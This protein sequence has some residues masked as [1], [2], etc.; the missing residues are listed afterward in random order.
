MTISEAKRGRIFDIRRFSTHDGGGIRTTVFFK[1]CP[2]RCKWC[3]N[4][5]GIDFARRPLWFKG[6]CMGCGSCVE[7]A[8]KGGVTMGEDGVC[9]HPLADENWDA[10]MEACPTLAIRWDSRDMTAD[11]VMNELRRDMAFYAHGGGV[12]LSGGDPLFQPEFAL[13]LLERCREAG[14][15]TAVETELHAS[16][17]SVHAVLPHADLIYADLKLMDGG[18]HREYTGADN[19]LILQNLSWL[20]GGECGERVVVRTPLIPGMTATEENIAA[21]AAYLAGINAAVQYEL[22]NYNPLAAAKYPLVDRDFC[23]D[24]NPR[25]FT[26]AEMEAF[27]DIARAQGLKNVIWE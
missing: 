24:E 5:E 22:L 12:T 8:E 2:L 4:P 18:L 7:T 19:G 21:I 25:R 9:L 3:H 15:H 20:L 26:M 16:P 1:G 13:E 14:I 27:A 17:E 23:F 11:E 6:R 10:V